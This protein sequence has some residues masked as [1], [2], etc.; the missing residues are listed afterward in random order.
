MECLRSGNLG[1]ILT[2]MRQ[3]KNTWRGHMHF[4]APS[5]IERGNWDSLLW[6]E[7]VAKYLLIPSLILTL[8]MSFP[9]CPTQLGKYAS[10]S[11]RLRDTVTESGLVWMQRK[12]HGDEV[13]NP[14][15]L[16]QWCL[17]NALYV[18]ELFDILLPDL[19]Q[20][21]QIIDWNNWQYHGSQ[22]YTCRYGSI[23]NMLL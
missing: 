23:M 15:E 11:L 7:P 18:D 1:Y 4:D 14:L 5:M 10:Y 19:L 13:I 2:S 3:S 6:K 22:L 12:N 21:L 9:S 16:L 17:I 8:L 20:S